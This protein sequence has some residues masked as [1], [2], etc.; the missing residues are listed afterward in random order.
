MALEPA[1]QFTAYKK[2]RLDHLRPKFSSK[3]YV[4]QSLTGPICVAQFTAIRT[5]LSTTINRGSAIGVPYLSV[6]RRKRPAGN[7]S[8]RESA[9]VGQ[10]MACGCAFP[11]RCLA[12]RSGARGATRGSPCGRA[13]DDTGCIS[14]MGRYAAAEP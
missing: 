7:G 14:K 11:D 6:A 8:V 12:P 4:L 2:K 1:G 10:P 5:V 3:S 9:L 13:D